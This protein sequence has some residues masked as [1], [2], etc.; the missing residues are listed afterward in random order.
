MINKNNN[1]KMSV[2]KSIII[3]LQAI[4]LAG[5]ITKQGITQNLLFAGFWILTI[6]SLIILITK[7]EWEATEWVA[8]GAFA[9]STI[10][11]VLISINALQDMIG[12]TIPVVG[13]L[14]VTATLYLEEKTTR[15][16]PPRAPKT[17]IKEVRIENKE[18]E[19]KK[20][21]TRKKTVKKTSEQ[22]TRKTNTKKKT[23][24]KKT[25]KKKTSKKQENKEDKETKNQ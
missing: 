3:L 20:K 24:K 16:K 17:I 1:N 22:K 18:K 6:T 9:T 15:I 7:K 19:T 21:T 13:L 4:L 12:V 11:G 10:T 2:G 25:S 8:F 23:S 5:V 14:L